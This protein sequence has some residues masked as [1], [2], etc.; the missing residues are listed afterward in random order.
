MATG[1][2]AS[3]AD[4]YPHSVTG[5]TIFVPISPFIEPHSGLSSVVVT[6]Y[7]SHTDPSIAA[8]VPLGDL[9]PSS[10]TGSQLAAP[11]MLTDL[12]DVLTIRVPGAIVVQDHFMWAHVA[13][14]NGVN[15]TVERAT[16]AVKIATESL[17]PG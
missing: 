17:K 5:A 10:T 11:V 15:M 16:R 13:V 6:T 14:T 2:C 9:L 3:V 12:Q 1:A 7:T 8:G 4:T